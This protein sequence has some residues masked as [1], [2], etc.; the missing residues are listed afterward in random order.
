MDWL[1]ACTLRFG[2]ALGKAMGE[3]LRSSLAGKPPIGNPRDPLIGFPML[4]SRSRLGRKTLNNLKKL[5][6]EGPSGSESC[7]ENRKNVACLPTHR[8]R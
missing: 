5:I 6:G 2:R 7:S 1:A 4:F 8:R 3:A